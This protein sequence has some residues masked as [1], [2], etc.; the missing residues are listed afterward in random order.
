MEENT[1]NKSMVTEVDTKNTIDSK[2]DMATS[3]GS[4][5]SAKSHA[6]TAPDVAN[7]QVPELSESDKENQSSVG[8]GLGRTPQ[9]NLT[10]PDVFE[11]P[12]GR[13]ARAA[14]SICGRTRE[15]SKRIQ[16]RTE[17]RQTAS[18]RTRADTRRDARDRKK[19]YIYIYISCTVGIFLKQAI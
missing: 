15:D 4:G 1:A 10:L 14:A 12:S 13:A 19:I 9:K 17:L 16:T 5:A 18:C 3:H 11:A 6:P 7:I 8:G 2:K